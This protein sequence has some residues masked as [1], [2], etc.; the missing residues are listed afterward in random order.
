VL[1]SDHIIFTDLATNPVETKEKILSELKMAT[2]KYTP[3]TKLDI[4]DPNAIG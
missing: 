3:S 1:K 4:F 2:I